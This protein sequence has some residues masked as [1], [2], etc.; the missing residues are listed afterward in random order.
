MDTRIYVI[1][2]KQCRLP[3]EDGYYPLQ[4]GAAIHETLPYEGDNTGD[5]IS[6]KNDTYCELTGMYWIWKNV[7]CDNVGLCHYRRYF[8]DENAERILKKS[9]YE[10][11]LEK[12]DVITT[13]PQAMN[14]QVYAHFVAHHSSAGLD[15]C[16]RVI[17]EKC[18][19]YME[20]FDKC[21][22]DKL[23]TCCNMMVTRKK[24][25][26]DYCSWLFTILF[27]VEREI[28]PDLCED[29]YHRRV[30]GFLGERLMRVWLM[31][32]DI[33]VSEIRMVQSDVPGSSILYGVI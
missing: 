25:F 18:P 6:L 32:Q 22:Q 27:E 8:S 15:I 20:S 12:Y 5:N 13:W 26:N 21:M 30:M 14:E 29:S 17:A 1:T 2:H 23:M 9:E 3:E 33:S 31:M 10:L 7:V 11:L 16:R 28:R 24:L 19:E 4:V